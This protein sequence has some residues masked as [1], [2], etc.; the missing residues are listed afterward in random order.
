[1]PLALDRLV[2]GVRPQSVGLHTDRRFC[3]PHELISVLLTHLQAEVIMPATWE[4]L[5]AGLLVAQS[6]A[7]PKPEPLPI[8]NCTTTWK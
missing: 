2:T 6:T 5:V 7:T 1:M 3:H 4:L 8:S